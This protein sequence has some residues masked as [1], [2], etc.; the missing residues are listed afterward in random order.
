MDILRNI[1]PKEV[2]KYFEEICKIPHGSGNTKEISDYVAD[3][4]K[5]RNLEYYQDNLNNVIIVKEGTANGEAVI[6]QGHLDM[7]CEKASDCIKD[8]EKEGLDLIV[9]GDYIKADKTTLGGDDGIAVAMMLALLD[10]KNIKHPGIEAVF[11]VDEETGMYGATAID[12]SMLKG[13][14][15]LNIDSEEEGIFTVSCA[16]GNVTN[17]IFDVER[18]D[19]D[20]KAYR[21]TVS[22]LTGGHSGVEIDKRRANANVLLSRILMSLKDNAELRIVNING[23]FKD[24]AITV[25]S[26]AKVCVSDCDA[27]ESLCTRMENAFK[28][29]YASTEKNL[30]VTACECEYEKPMDKKSTDAVIA[31]LGCAP[32]G[33]FEMSSEIEGLVQTSLNIGTVKTTETEFN[34]G[35]CI[36]SSID[37]QKEML[38]QRIKALT[39]ILGGRITVNGDYPGWEYKKDSVL[40]DVMIEV[41]EKQYG[42]K[43]KIQAIH[44]GLECGLFAGKIKDLDC[45]SFGPELLE[46]HTHRER[47]SISSVQRTWKLLLSVLERLSE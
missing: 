18:V 25:E 32:N 12:L 31:A 5:E 9:D 11:T 17:S 46:I 41:Y 29:E 16:G 36:R 1:E 44:A 37:T 33:I 20:G 3:F 35:F 22:G 14:K 43:P 40:R 6:L 10:N 28:N 27:L 30:K 42:K 24:N 34:I 21:I 8:M 39:E 2:L 45:I 38:T 4:A 26:T 7:V 47:M 23:G 19:F 13:K 15:M